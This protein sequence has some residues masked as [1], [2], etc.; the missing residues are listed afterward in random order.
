MKNNVSICLFDS[1]EGRFRQGEKPD[2]YVMGKSPV[3]FEDIDHDFID[4][5]HNFYT[6]TTNSRRP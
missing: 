3:N 4:A 1:K 5:P 2:E 6:D